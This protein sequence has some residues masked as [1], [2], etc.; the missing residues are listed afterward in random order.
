LNTSPIAATNF[1][2]RREVH[3]RTSLSDAQIYRLE[4][5]G[6]FPKRVKLSQRAVGWIESE[7]DAWIEARIRVAGRIPAPPLPRRRRPDDQTTV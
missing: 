6:K 4:A 5:E 7:V 2:R 3:R 1:I